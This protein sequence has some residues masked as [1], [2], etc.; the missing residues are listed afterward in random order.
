[1][2]ERAKQFVELSDTWRRSAGRSFPRGNLQL[3]S[4]SQIWTSRYRKSVTLFARANY[5][6]ARTVKI[7]QIGLRKILRIRNPNHRKNKFRRRKQR[8]NPIQD[9]DSGKDQRQTWVQLHYSSTHPTNWTS[10]YCAQSL[11]AFW[12]NQ[13]DSAYSTRYSAIFQESVILQIWEEPLFIPKR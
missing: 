5:P 9:Q 13:H 8:H 4:I 6:L 2:C 11:F 3:L 1:M 7:S 10:I 12:T